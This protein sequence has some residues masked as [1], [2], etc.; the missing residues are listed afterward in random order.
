MLKIV[1]STYIENAIHCKQRTVESGNLDYFANCC[2]SIIRKENP[3]QRSQT[4][5][6][7]EAKSL[8]VSFSSA[9]FKN[10]VL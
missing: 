2:P 8:A 3:L 9:T 10:F 4:D 6:F 5:N 1:E 7:D